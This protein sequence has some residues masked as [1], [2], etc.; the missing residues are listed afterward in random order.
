MSWDFFR[1]A[2]KDQGLKPTVEARE[3]AHET[4]SGVFAH[5][6]SA[7]SQTTEGLQQTTRNDNYL[8]G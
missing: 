2:A 4:S 1:K 7:G 3:E 8:S 6:T 5:V